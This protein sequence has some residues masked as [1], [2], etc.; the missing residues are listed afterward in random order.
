VVVEVVVIESNNVAV[1]AGSKLDA[2]IGHVDFDL[3]AGFD[4]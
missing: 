4:R 1:W 3:I 2:L